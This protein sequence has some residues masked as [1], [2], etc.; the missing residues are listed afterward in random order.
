[1]TE[2]DTV[3]LEA[4]FNKTENRIK[5][6]ENEMEKAKEKIR[7]HAEENYAKINVNISNISKYAYFFHAKLF[8]SITLTE[9]YC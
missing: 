9:I 7:L 6:L 8:I 2:K 4:Q 1:M 3:K 5:T